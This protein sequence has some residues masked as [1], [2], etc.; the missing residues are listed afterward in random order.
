[1]STELSNAYKE[2][3]NNGFCFGDFI[4]TLISSDF[5]VQVDS[6]VL[7]YIAEDL[8]DIYY[9]VPDTVKCPDLAGIIGRVL[10]I[11]DQEAE[12]KFARLVSV[13]SNKFEDA[14]KSD[15]INGLISQVNHLD[16][17]A[18]LTYPNSK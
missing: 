5:S 15:G 16:D 17:I 12:V 2:R 18:R 13:F 10:E 3:N 9:N 6:Q 14:I 1:M 7:S 4:Y 11:S 8:E